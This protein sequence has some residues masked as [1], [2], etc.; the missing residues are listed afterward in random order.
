MPLNGMSEITFTGNFDNSV[1]EMSK[2]EPSVELITTVKV[3]RHE[4]AL[5]V[6]AK[7]KLDIIEKVCGNMGY[8]LM[9]SNSGEKPERESAQL[10]S[11]IARGID[12]VFIVPCIQNSVFGRSLNA[13]KIPYVLLQRKPNDH[14][15]NFVQSDDFEGGYLAAQHLY[16]QGHRTF[17]LIFPSLLNPSAKERYQG[18]LSYLRERNVPDHSLSVLECDGTRDSG[19]EVMRNWLSERIQEPMLEKSAVF[20]FSD[21]VAAGVYSAIKEFR[22]RIPDDL[23]VIGYD[24]NEYSDIVFPP[25]TTV[26]ILS[27]DV[28]KHAARLMLDILQSDKSSVTDAQTKVIISPKLIVRGSTG[29]V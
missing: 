19:Y 16:E 10:D 12:G 6:A 18:F 15:A 21:Y 28:G 29:R 13:A 2:K 26:D 4:Y 14:P 27:Y 7:A 22:L 23:S 9:L 1:K 20:C 3:P 5:L 17:L 11:M 25:L 8:T 24:N